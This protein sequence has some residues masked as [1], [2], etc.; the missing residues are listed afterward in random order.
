[1]AG[2]HTA[3][4]AKVRPKARAR[5][6]T[7]NESKI[8]IGFM[9][10]SRKTRRMNASIRN[11]GIGSWIVLKNSPKPR[12]E[13]RSTRPDDH[14]NAPPRISKPRKR[15]VPSHNQ[16]DGAPEL[17]S[18]AGTTNPPRQPLC[19]P[20][21]RRPIPS[22][23]VVTQHPPPA[24]TPGIPFNPQPEFQWPSVVEP[25]PRRSRPSRTIHK[26]PAAEIRNC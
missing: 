1:M 8:E 22:K 17:L 5:P 14:A 26:I 20:R 13:S 10:E 23:P 4:V 18:A 11:D 24:P 25:W 12:P 3:T 6:A 21:C 15:R 2:V 9:R 16:K 7:V 19:Q